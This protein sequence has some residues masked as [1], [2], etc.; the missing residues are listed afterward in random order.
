MKKNRINLIKSCAKVVYYFGLLSALFLVVVLWPREIITLTEIIVP[1]FLVV[2]VVLLIVKNYRIY[3][4]GNFSKRAWFAATSLD[5]LGYILIIGLAVLIAGGLGL[6]IY[7]PVATEIN[8]AI[9][10]MGDRIAL[11]VCIILALCVGA[12][13][14]Y[15][16][17]GLLGKIKVR[18]K[19]SPGS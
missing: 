16:V 4:K 6:L 9:A 18:A 17:H 5:V 15:L 2:S 12:A 11:F 13:V 14:S 10:G 19:L 1:V 7:Q 3:R 8:R